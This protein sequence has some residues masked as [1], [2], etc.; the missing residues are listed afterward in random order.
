MVGLRVAP[1]RV[2]QA[3]GIFEVQPE[4]VKQKGAPVMG[5]R[6]PWGLR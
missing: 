6:G 4:V 3:A 5:R 2:R 1:R